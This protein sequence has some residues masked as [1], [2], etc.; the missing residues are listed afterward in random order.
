MLGNRLG[1]RWKPR[2]PK[3]GEFPL[4]CAG[5]IWLQ[6]GRGRLAAMRKATSTGQ[7]IETEPEGADTH[8]LGLWKK[9]H[10]N[11]DGRRFY[12]DSGLW[13][14]LV[15]RCECLEQ[16]AENQP[17]IA[18]C[19]VPIFRPARAGRHSRWPTD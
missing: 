4:R 6:A 13:R 16:R 9:G 19:E 15:N 10:M 14:K 5:V 7:K 18:G 3:V 17:R 11:N 8:L 12:P 2:R 1:A